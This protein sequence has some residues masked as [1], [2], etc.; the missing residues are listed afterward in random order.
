MSRAV[1]IG[2]ERRLGGYALAGVEVAPAAD[3]GDAAAA[4]QALADD[5][6]LVVLDPPAYAA[7]APRLDERPNVVWA[8]LPE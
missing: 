7:L 6:A 8:V 1:A 5:V 3:A 2:D 4:W